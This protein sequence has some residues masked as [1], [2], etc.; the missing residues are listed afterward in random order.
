[1]TSI[2]NVN[3]SNNV[4]PRYNKSES[5]GSPNI[6]N[7]N[8]GSIFDMQQK[9]GDQYKNVKTSDSGADYYNDAG[10]VDYHVSPDISAIT[11][12]IYDNNGNLISFNTYQDSDRNGTIDQY[13][14]TKSEQ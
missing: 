11:K 14:V 13:T 1:M 8:L 9:I 12:Y 10:K 5:D 6:I 4:E 7:G 2:S 3:S